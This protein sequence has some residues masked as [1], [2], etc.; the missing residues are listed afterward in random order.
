MNISD[1]FI[2][3]KIKNKPK[4]FASNNRVTLDSY[5]GSAN[6]SIDD[7]LRLKPDQAKEQADNA[8]NQAERIA[9]LKKTQVKIWSILT[10]AM[11]YQKKV[12][13]KL[14]KDWEKIFLS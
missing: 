14:Q 9:L 1:N 7:F 4:A 5:Q 8:I 13:L 2:N 6:L 10:E 12:F 3:T 11:L